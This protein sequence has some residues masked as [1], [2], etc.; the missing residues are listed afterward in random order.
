MDV[1]DFEIL[2]PKVEKI[3]LRDRK[4]GREYQADLF[5]PTAV[6]LVFVRNID[7]VRKIFSGTVDDTALRLIYDIFEKMFKRQFDFMDAKWCERNIDL[8]TTLVI[9][10]QIAR[11]IFDYLKLTGI[12]ATPADEKKPETEASSSPE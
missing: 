2:V 1:R 8:Q 12:L 6:G 7:A 5:V 3:K 11:P 9:I 10:S 4:N